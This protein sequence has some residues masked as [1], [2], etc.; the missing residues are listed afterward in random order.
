MMS[1]IERVESF[2]L[3]F[4]ASLG[5][6][7]A[8]GFVYVF[9]VIFTN[10]SKVQKMADQLSHRDEVREAETRAIL[11]QFRSLHKEVSDLR[12]DIRALYAFEL[13]DHRRVKYNEDQSEG[14]G[15]HSR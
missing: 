9:R 15:V 13:Q 11:E 4:W 10:Q 14:R 7:V 12:A 8:G 3:A 1:W 5:A 2:S 6:A